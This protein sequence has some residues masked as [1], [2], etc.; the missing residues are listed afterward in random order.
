MHKV[1]L[2]AVVAAIAA[3]VGQSVTR[4]E[5]ALATVA[6]K[7]TAPSPALMM[8]DSG[9]LPATPFVAP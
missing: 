4:G 1:I 9:N 7:D 6:D 3:M 2:I 8:A 5:H